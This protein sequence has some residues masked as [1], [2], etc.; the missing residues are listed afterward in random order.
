MARGGGAGLTPVLGVV[1][2]LEGRAK[3]KQCRSDNQQDSERA[4]QAR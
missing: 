3:G 4:A 1:T 2:T